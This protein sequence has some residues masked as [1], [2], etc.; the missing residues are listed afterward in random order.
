MTQA[1]PIDYFVCPGCSVRLTPETSGATRCPHCKWRG[2]A[3][4][5]APKPLDVSQAEMA[6]PEDAA[7]LHHPRK[8]ATA[9]CAG[10]GDYICALCAVEIE[11]QTFSAAFLDKGGKEKAKKAFDRTL[12]RPDR[13][14]YTY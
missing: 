2:D 4:L 6:L 13:H 7:C 12:P 10:T 1:L 14:V 8:K 3:Y 5:F 11:G 9:V